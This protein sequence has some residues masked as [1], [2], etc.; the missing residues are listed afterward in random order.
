MLEQDR[1][2]KA[3]SFFYAEKD[4]QEIQQ[5]KDRALDF[6]R[7]E[8][9]LYKLRVFEQSLAGVECRRALEET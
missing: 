2:Q 6:V 8:E 1:L 3:D 7:Q 4:M 9:R 5:D